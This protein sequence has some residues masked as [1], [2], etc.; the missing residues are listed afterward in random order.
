MSEAQR[1]GILVTQRFPGYQ[2][3]PGV[4]YHYPKSQYQRRLQNLVGCFVLFYEPRRGGEFHGS[5]SGG[6][7]A[8]VGGAYV[9]RLSDDPT[10]PSHGFAWFRFAMDFSTIVPRTSTSI[11][12]RRLQSVVLDDAPYQLVETIVGIGLTVDVGENNPTHREGLSDVEELVSI[13][14]RP[15]QEVTTNRRLR[16]QS[17]RYRVVERV[18]AGTC[19]FTGICMTNGRG[20]AEADAAHIRPVEQDGPD[21]IRNGIALM[22]SIHWAFDRGLVS[23]SDGGRILTTERGID[24]SLRRLFR[25]DGI[26]LLPKRADERPHP[27]F[28]AW[29][30]EH[31]FKGLLPRAEG[32]RGL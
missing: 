14:T 10:D 8:F 25:S 7:E 2:D 18:Y 21:T 31:V 12:G 15:L 9:D 16:D 20:R 11:T 13:K 5:N 30:R 4:C 26:A 24:S 6:R 27:A 22:K 28:L 1:V 3:I 29:H 19:A 32:H 17:F 23:M